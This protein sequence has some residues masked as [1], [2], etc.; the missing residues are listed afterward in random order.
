MNARIYLTS[1]RAAS[2]YLFLS[3]LYKP[4]TN[5]HQSVQATLNL[6]YPDFESVGTT[7]YYLAFPLS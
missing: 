2:L 3:N 4:I 6:K 7:L 5:S 1:I